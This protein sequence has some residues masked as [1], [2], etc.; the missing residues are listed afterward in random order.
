MSL[1]KFLVVAMGL[2]LAQLCVAQAGE[3][4][5]PAESV[6]SRTTLDGT[7]DEIAAQMQQMYGYRIAFESPKYAF[8]GDLE[9]Q[10]DVVRQD[11][12]KYSQGEAPKVLAI[13]R[14]V[15]S[16]KVE[17][18]TVVDVEY[19]A[20]RLDEL[21]QA[22]NQTAAGAHFR[23]ERDPHGFRILPTEV[24][25]ANSEWVAEAPILDTQISIPSAPRT[26]LEMITVI[27][28][29]VSMATRIKGGLMTG[30]LSAL[31][32]VSGN[33][34]A[35]NEAARIVLQ[36]VL[37]DLR[38]QYE[39]DLGWV[40]G[41]IPAPETFGLNITWVPPRSVGSGEAPKRVPGTSGAT[42]AGGKSA[43]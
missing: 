3:S 16:L 14:N 32:S 41:Y 33:W 1:A 22:H 23:V 4:K 36:R 2:V 31:Q 24:R 40:L 35:K 42:N 19:V 28:E 38:L 37:S 17:P 18:E 29:S 9:D 21:M 11:L 25:K 12:S 15:L 10:T 43:R 26:A 39:Y 7:I 30:P 5:T 20:G 27:G 13:R 8:L 34:G 6:N